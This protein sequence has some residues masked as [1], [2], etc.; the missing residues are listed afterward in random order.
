MLNER[1]TLPD[2]KWCVSLEYWNLFIKSVLLN[3]TRVLIISVLHCRW[4]LSLLEPDKQLLG[5]CLIWYTGSIYNVNCLITQSMQTLLV[6]NKYQAVITKATLLFFE[7]F[8][9][10]CVME[11]WRNYKCFFVTILLKINSYSK[12]IIYTQ[13]EIKV[14]TYRMIN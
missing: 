14:L 10:L 8:I 5:S 1:Q 4:R 11:I 9:S 3:K 6:A 7:E 2:R 12:S 13:Q